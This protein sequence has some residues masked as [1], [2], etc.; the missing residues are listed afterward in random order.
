MAMSFSPDST[1]LAT[2]DA[3]TAIRVYELFIG[4]AG[5]TMSIVDPLTG[6]IRDTLPNNPVLSAGSWLQPMA[7]KSARCIT[8]PIDSTRLA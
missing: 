4:G 1:L 2:A 6:K 8:S 7:S 3:D 5:K